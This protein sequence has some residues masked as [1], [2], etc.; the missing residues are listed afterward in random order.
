M[1]IVSSG[2]NLYEMSKL[3][4]WEKKEKKKIFQNV[5]FWF[6]TEHAGRE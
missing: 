6:F 5:V 4:F 3:I 2:D 1:Q